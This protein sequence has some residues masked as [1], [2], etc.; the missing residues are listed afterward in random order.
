VTVMRTYPTLASC[1]AQCVVEDPGRTV[2]CWVDI[3][4]SVCFSLSFP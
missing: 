2:T 4:W 3:F 1:E